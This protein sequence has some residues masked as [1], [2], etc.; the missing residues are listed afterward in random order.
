MK[1][2]PAVEDSE[3]E[4]RRFESLYD[5]NAILHR[6]IEVD[7]SLSTGALRNAPH[8]RDAVPAFLLS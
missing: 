4:R 8:A 2:V 6:Q 3:N 7:L 1:T 5:W